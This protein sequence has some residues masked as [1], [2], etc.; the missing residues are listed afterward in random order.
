MHIGINCLGLNPKIG[1][2]RQY[3][4]RLIQELLESDLE[5]TYSIF[6]LSDNS[7]EIELIDAHR[8]QKS[9]VQVSGYGD[10][11]SKLGQLDVYFCPFGVLWPR[12]VPV[13]TIVNLSDIQEEFYPQY[14]T[15]RALDGR[16]RHY[17]PSTR[18]ADCVLT[19]SEF[20]KR[21]IVEKHGISPEKIFVAYHS[22]DSNMRDP[23]STETLA[24]L[25]LPDR[26]IFYPANHW[27]HKNHDGLLRALCY[28]RTEKKTIIPCILTGH[29]QDNGYSVKQ[30]I[31]EYRLSD[32]VK[33]LGYVTDEDIRALYHRSAMLCFPSLFEG[34]GMPLVDAMA[35]GCPIACSYV[36]SIP[37]VTGD[38]AIFFDPEDEKQIGEA[39]YR[40]WTDPNLCNNLVKSGKERVKLFTSAKMADVHLAAFKTAHE[41]FDSESKEFFD[42]E[43]WG[44]LNKLSYMQ[45]QISELSNKIEAIQSS[46]SW[47]ITAPL[48][49]SLDL[50]RQMAGR[51]K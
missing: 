51:S 14:F 50:L 18:A 19:V 47:R 43:V 37:E 22:V 48:R 7:S 12:P 45:Y 35:V 29:S 41:K 21:T 10:L 34:F 36:A 15:Q 27:H 11:F 44:N 4:Q 3:V 33:L 13:A 30:K 16:R 39:I 40:L 17:G 2:L 8:L 49:K 28:L 42:H 26:Y 38:A 9:R 1:G 23:V 24:R 32:Q 25:D 20:S 6:H 31:E 5:N 46:L